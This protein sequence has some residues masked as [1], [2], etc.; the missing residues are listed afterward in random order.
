MLLAGLSVLISLLMQ[1]LAP[2]GTLRAVYL[3]NNPAQ[4]MKDP[5]S[6]EAMPPFEFSRKRAV[7]RCEQSRENQSQ[8][9]RH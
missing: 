3:A 4:A 5:V 7:D 9:D 8:K 2:T 6:G 1:A